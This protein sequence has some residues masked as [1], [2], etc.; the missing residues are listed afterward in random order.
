MRI[1][2]VYVLMIKINKLLP[3]C[4]IVTFI[5]GIVTSC[6][7]NNSSDLEQIAYESGESVKVSSFTFDQA[8]EASNCAVTA[9]F[10]SNHNYDDYNELE[11]KVIEVIYGYV[12][13]KSIMVIEMDE[14]NCG[15]YSDHTYK[16]SETYTLVLNRT[17]SIFYDHARYSFI[18]DI[19]IP[20]SE[21]T[22]SISINGESIVTVRNSVLNKNNI[23]QY[24]KDI[25]K[26]KTNLSEIRKDIDIPFTTATNFSEIIPASDYVMEIVIKDIAVEGTIHNGN[27]YIC[28]I[29]DVL[30]GGIPTTNENKEIWVTFLKD[31]VKVGKNYITMLNQLGDDSII[32]V[33]SSKHSIV[34]PD[35]KTALEQIK[36][37]VAN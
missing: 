30:K 34:S 33:Q 9:T 14:Q 35:N 11:F 1:M 20:I 6:G 27:T 21:N 23:N 24:L 18:S 8:I 36:K 13:E 3:F 10:V 31:S 26:S 4:L 22:S 7:S 37:I 25:G 17:D 5:L 19:F 28:D 32:Y 16:E 29:V 15:E 12:P 2:E